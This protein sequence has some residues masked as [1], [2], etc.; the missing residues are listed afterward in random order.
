MTV[1][2]VEIEALRGKP[3]RELIQKAHRAAQETYKRRR[4]GKD[5]V[6]RDRLKE[7][8]AFRAGSVPGVH[9]I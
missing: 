4:E 6:C 5:M 1:G 2:P 7:P 3:W 9:H 8:V